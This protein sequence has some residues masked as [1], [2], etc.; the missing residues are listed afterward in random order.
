[1]RQLERAFCGKINM[2]NDTYNEF[3]SLFT[4]KLDSWTFFRKGFVDAFGLRQTDALSRSERTFNPDRRQVF[5][6]SFENRLVSLGGLA[7][8][9]RLLPHYLKKFGEDVKIVT[10]CHVNHPKVRDALQN[11][12]LRRVLGP[13]V[14]HLCGYEG[15][16]SCFEDT[17]AQVPS[18]FIAVE[19]KFHAAPDPYVYS[20]SEKLLEDSLSFCAA[21][22]FV[23]ERLGFSNDLIFHAHDWETAPVA[24][25]SKLA[26]V[27]GLLQNARTVLTLHNSFDSGISVKTKMRFFGKNIPGHT[28]LQCVI[29]LLN[30]PLSTVSTP[31]ALELRFDPLQCTIFTDHLQ[32]I[33]SM[34]PPI[35]IENGMFG[36]AHSPFTYTA[37]SRAR[38]GDFT[39][40]LKQKKG[41]RERLAEVVEKKKNSLITGNLKLSQSSAP[42]LFMSGRMDL[43][44]KGFDVI[45]QAFRRLPKGSAKLLFSPSSSNGNSSQELDLFCSIEKECRGDIAI[46]PFRISSADY[47]SLLLG[48]SFL[49]MPSLYEPFGAATEGFLHATPVLAR[50]TGGLWVQIKPC[51]RVNTPAFYHS[52]F[53][54]SGSGE[55]ATGILYRE[56]V[57][58]QSARIEWKKCLSLPVARRVESPLYRSMIDSAYFALCDALNIYSD[59]ETYGKMILNGTE[60]VKRFSWANAVEKYQKVF[61]TAAYRGYL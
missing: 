33:F 16:V 1:M 27:D 26:V 23:L 3:D 39:L 11:G 8:V 50:G 20:D 13:V 53:P 44:Q 49:L 59:G 60:C 4:T 42:I 28:V 21:V 32:K 7:A 52:L 48:S 22:P 14:F 6:L 17:E 29:P 30:G 31:F 45:F 54:N 55:N 12:V 38:S 10:P 25:T 24:I 43:M 15:E 40:L 19:G 36:R 2:N 46:W 58:E 35:G 56:Q 34:N 37:L 61:E 47:K 41:F 57:Q 18:Y 5:F 51:N 9:T